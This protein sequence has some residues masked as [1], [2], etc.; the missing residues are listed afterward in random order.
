MVTVEDL[1]EEIV[2]NIFDEYDRG[3]EP[4]F[5]KIDENTY[6]FSGRISLDSV[7]ELMKIKI[8][9]TEYETLGGYLVGELGRIP[10]VEEKPVLELE[11]VVFRVEQIAG[12]RILKVKAAKL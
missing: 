11:S 3:D 2:G 4:E 8:P 1:L 7:E 10:T 6:L 5:K 9:I 12:K